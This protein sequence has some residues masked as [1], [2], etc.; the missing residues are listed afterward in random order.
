[1]SIPCEKT[2]PSSAN[3][4]P[5]AKNAGDA[6]KVHGIH[7]SCCVLELIRAISWLVMARQ[8]AIP[9]L[10]NGATSAPHT[11]WILGAQL[12]F[13]GVG[14][15]YRSVSVSL[16]IAMQAREPEAWNSAIPAQRYNVPN[17]TDLLQARAAESDDVCWYCRGSVQCMA[18][19]SVDQQ[20]HADHPILNMFKQVEA[21]R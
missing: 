10:P 4:L 13:G 16:C 15:S 20:K 3:A 18:G 7:A 6:L 9:G 2:R 12:P 21:L 1:M 11:Q 5:C 19:N 14:D 17:L 8:G